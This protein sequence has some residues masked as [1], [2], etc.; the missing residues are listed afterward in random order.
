[1]CRNAVGQITD[2]QVSAFA[3][4][5]GLSAAISRGGLGSLPDNEFSEAL[6]ALRAPSRL[7]VYYADVHG[8]SYRE[9]AGV[10]AI[11]RWE[12]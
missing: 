5:G 2:D 7:T 11:P 1:M 6:M 8:Y 3:A 9:I 10:M 12:R 4:C